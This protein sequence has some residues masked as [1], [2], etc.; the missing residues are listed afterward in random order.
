MSKLVISDSSGYIYTIKVNNLNATKTYAALR[1]LL[2]S[3]HIDNTT[4]FTETPI[5]FKVGDLVDYNNGDTYNFTARVWEITQLRAKISAIDEID[6]LFNP[7]VLTDVY[8]M[9]LKKHV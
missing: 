5:N 8:T 3:A 7:R 6:N 2:N 9:Y 4:I 1:T